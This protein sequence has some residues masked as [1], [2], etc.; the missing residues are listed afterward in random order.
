[1]ENKTI[2]YK[3]GD[4]YIGEVL[5]NTH[6]G[7]GVYF[8]K[9]GEIYEGNFKNGLQNGIGKFIFRNKQIINGIWK[10]GKYSIRDSKK[11]DNIKND[12]NFCNYR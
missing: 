8:Y 5:E 9:N 3:N 6:N 4:K 11:I 12:I 1:M 7:Y 10:N 2:I